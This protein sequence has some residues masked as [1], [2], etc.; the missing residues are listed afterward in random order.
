MYELFHNRYMLHNNVCKH[1]VAVAIEMMWVNLENQTALNFMWD[2]GKHQLS[3]WSNIMFIPLIFTGL[4]MHFWKLKI[5]LTWVAWSLIKLWTLK[6]TGN[7]QVHTSV[8]PRQYF[9]SDISILY[10]FIKHKIYSHTSFGWAYSQ[11]LWST[12]NF[13]IQF[14]RI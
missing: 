8:S 9:L 1:K 13:L 3:C 11:S 4:L 14:N 6:D 2:L 10:V 7:S 12:V 5:T